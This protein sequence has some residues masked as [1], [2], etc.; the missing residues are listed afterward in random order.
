MP[1]P[2]MH[3]FYTKQ[4]LEA[5][6]SDVPVPSAPPPSEGTT[7][8]T[9]NL[10]FRRP[11]L[12]TSADIAAPLPG[13][14]T[15][16]PCTNTQCRGNKHFTVD[17]L[18]KTPKQPDSLFLHPRLRE[19][20]TDVRHLI[21][22]DGTAVISPGEHIGSISALPHRVSFGPSPSSA[23]FREDSPSSSIC[24][25]EE[26]PDNVILHDLAVAETDAFATITPLLH[27][28]RRPQGLR[29]TPGGVADDV[30]NAIED[31]AAATTPHDRLVLPRWRW[32]LACVV[33]F[34]KPERR[35]REWKHL[36]F[37]SIYI[38]DDWPWLPIWRS[39]VPPAGQTYTPRSS[40]EQRTLE[41]YFT[42]CSIFGSSFNDEGLH[43][44]AIKVTDTSWKRI[45]GSV[46]GQLQL[47]YGI[48]LPLVKPK[49]PFFLHPAGNYPEL[50][51]DPELRAAFVKGHKKMCDWGMVIGI[52]SFQPFD[53]VP[54]FYL[55]QLRD[56]GSI[57]SRG[58]QD[59][60]AS[61]LNFVLAF[62]ACVLLGLDDIHD[63]TEPDEYIAMRD[64]TSAF[65][66]WVYNCRFLLLFGAKDPEKNFVILCC[67]LMG[68]SNSPAIQQFFAL[69][70][71][72]ALDK[73]IDALPGAVSALQRRGASRAS[74]YLDD[75]TLR[76]G[77]SL[78]AAT[79]LG[80][81]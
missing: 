50:Y 75:F 46:Y 27:A 31:P 32:C 45:G 14:R 81:Y 40:Q 72:R 66:H 29:Y 41:A 21:D 52:L 80:V 7:A 78:A 77:R 68:I 67:V 69:D 19:S 23:F 13:E 11:P 36:W 42:S 6:A 34:D 10:P 55:E 5:F 16:K 28:I 64:L 65:W 60:A 25:C 44:P 59:A 20:T 51:R 30:I 63:F 26:H 39:M 73:H 57:K 2:S 4:R 37:A 74:P 47:K 56:D 15:R 70:L 38:H 12:V 22:I 79:R 8:L 53:T 48:S 71:A 9:D 61:G 43:V 49:R 18:E 76:G 54:Q 62:V 17:P 33:R 24:L 3:D 58:I 1:A 35:F